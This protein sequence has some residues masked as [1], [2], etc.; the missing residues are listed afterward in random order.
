MSDPH[1]VALGARLL[2]IKMTLGVLVEQMGASEPGVR[3]RVRGKL[4]SYLSGLDPAA[5]LEHDEIG[6]R[7][8]KGSQLAQI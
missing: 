6:I 4:E 1:N 2:S 7:G 5:E 8:A 3:D